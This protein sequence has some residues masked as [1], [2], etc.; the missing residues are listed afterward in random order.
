M[1]VLFIFLMFLTALSQKKTPTI[2]TEDVLP[3]NVPI[4]RPSIQPNK[5]IN[6]LQEVVAGVTTQEDVE[7]IPGIKK[8]SEQNGTARYI[9]PSIINVRPHEINT[10]GGIATDE[11][12]VLPEI[13][14]QT[15]FTTISSVVEKYGQPERILSGST[16]YGDFV[17]R[18][19]YPKKGLLFVVNTNTN[20]VFEILHFQPMELTDFVKNYSNETSVV[21]KGKEEF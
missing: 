17:S 21:L 11:R 16:F 12:I 2:K 10:R 13:E 14:G 20:E 3:T 1:F 4:A 5:T 9:L 19:L 15:G 8:V 6:P 18:Y 7:K